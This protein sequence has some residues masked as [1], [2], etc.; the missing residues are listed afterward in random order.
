VNNQQRPQKI[1]ALAIRRSVLL[2]DRQ[3]VNAA[4]SECSA[5]VGDI[6]R[7]YESVCL[8]RENNERLLKAID[9]EISK[10]DSLQKM[11]DNSCNDCECGGFYLD[12]VLLHSA[13]CS[14]FEWKSE[15]NDVGAR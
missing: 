1:D 5:R 15:C 12:G 13:R 11:H 14:S 4:I 9:A 6:M 2:R 8:R 3:R 10:V 7:E